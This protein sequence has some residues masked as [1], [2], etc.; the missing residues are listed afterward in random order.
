MKKLL[1]SVMIALAVMAVSV[2]AEVS[3]TSQSYQKV[4]KKKKAKWVEATKIVPGT[5]VLYMNTLKNKGKKTAEKLAI[6]N[7][8]PEH[9]MYLKGTSASKSKAKVTYSVDAGKTFNTPKKLYVKDKKTKKRRRAKAS[10][11]TT[12]MWVVDKL[13]GGKSTVVQYKAKLK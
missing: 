2:Q 5:V 8:I 1:A 10:E 9:M 12:I 4:I 3:I 13:K 11:Y 6:V 7:A